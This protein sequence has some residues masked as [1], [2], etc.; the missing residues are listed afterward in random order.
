MSSFYPESEA[1]PDYHKGQQNGHTV[2]RSHD[3]GAPDAMLQALG[4]APELV[5]NRST[6]QVAFMSF[7]LASIPYGLATTLLYPLT[8]GGM[9]CVIWGWLAV[10]LIIIC[11]AASLGEIT[12]VFPTAGG[13]YYQTYM[14][15]PHYCRRI[16]AYLCGWNMVIGQVTI[17]LAVQYGTALF[18]IGCINI[19]TDA[20]G[21]PIFANTTWQTFLIFLAIVIVCNL[22]CALGN[23]WLPMLDT[24]AVGLTFVGV[25]ALV[26]VILVLAKG[27]RRSAEFVFTD[28]TPQSGWTPG[29]SWMIGLLHAAYATSSTGMIINMAEE[30]RDPAI[31]IPKAML[32]T[33]VANTICGLF[34]LIPLMFVIPEVSEVILNLQPVPVIVNAAVGNQGGAFAL[35][36]PL[37]L[38]A[39]CC[40]CC[41]TTACARCIWSFARDEAMPGFQI[42]NKVNRSLDVPLNAMMLSM[43][44]QILLGLITF[45][46]SA[47]FS[48]FSGVG[49]IA[50]TLSYAMPI[51]VSLL[52]GRKYVRSGRFYLGAFGAVA[53]VVALAWSLLVIPLFCMPLV[54]PVTTATM[55]YASVVFVGFTAIAAVWYLVYSRKHYSGPPTSE[56]AVADVAHKHSMDK[57]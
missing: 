48:A 20:D 1:V 56:G 24:A 30:V 37:I 4:Y 21:N 36:V 7:V 33:V 57:A 2:R 52:G 55:N 15:A 35:M 47:G 10:S 13:V 29:W 39:V 17:T 12:S 11:V 22:V 5:R 50:L 46:S 43:G 9:T 32:A 49:V 19:F 27:G 16:L 44:V 3:D 14:L 34:F 8:G 40:G 31:Q 28:F 26:I 38:L 18:F 6:F 41:C 45:G 51:A 25:I 42:W 54:V 53:N 23:K